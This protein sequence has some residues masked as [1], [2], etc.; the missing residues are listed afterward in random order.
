MIDRAAE[1][2]LRQKVELGLLDPGWDP[3]PS[4]L[5]S[6]PITLDDT[7]SRALARRLAQRSVV[8][9]SNDGTLPLA[10]GRRISVVGPRADERSAMMG[11]YSFP[12]HVG[13]QHPDVPMGVDVATVLD[14]LSGSL[15]ALPFAAG[16][17]V[18]GGDDEEIAEAVAVAAGLRRLRRRAR[19]PGRTVRSRHVRRR[20]RRR[21]PDGCPAGRRSCSRRCWRPAFPVVLVLLLGRPYDLSRQ[22]DR[23]AAMVCGF[24]PGE[25]GAAAVAGVLTGE[26][27]PSG[28]LPVSFPGAGSTQPSTYLGAPLARRSAVSSVD[29]TA[30]FPFGFGLSY[31]PVTWVDVSSSDE[32]WTTDGT[33]DV[34]VS[35]QNGHGRPTT[36]VVQ[37]YLHDLQAEVVRPVQQLVGLRPGRPRAG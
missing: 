27:N 23:L 3:E 20:L 24:F 22:A 16:G 18:T 2:V 5:G 21:R 19:G 31:A 4:A 15:G 34:S 29:P 8:L 35:L 6:D 14:A 7:E 33:Y 37:V 30:L 26:V 12:L 32:A 17:T 9:L 10:T 13:A 36:E 25:E 28:R 11:C 1:R